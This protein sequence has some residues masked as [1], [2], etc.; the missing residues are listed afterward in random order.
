MEVEV[1]TGKEI[2]I[3]SK[4]FLAIN[5]AI[6][7]SYTPSESLKAKTFT[8]FRDNI[9]KVRPSNSDQGEYTFLFIGTVKNS[10]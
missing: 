2:E 8:S 6:K 1:E 7:Y 5:P 10:R 4:Q 3:V 9:L